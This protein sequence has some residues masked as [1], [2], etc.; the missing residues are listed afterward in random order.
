MIPDDKPPDLALSHDSDDSLNNNNDSFSHPSN[1]AVEDFPVGIDLVVTMKSAVLIPDIL[2]DNRDFQI[3]TDAVRGMASNDPTNDLTQVLDG[4]VP[5]DCR[6]DRVEK[7]GDPGVAWNDPDNDVDLGMACINLPLY[8]LDNKDQGVYGEDPVVE[9][10]EISSV[11]N[12][13]HTKDSI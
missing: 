9:F 3:Q 1:F 2:I 13:Y 5:C 10:K 6:F 4:G 12:F 11:P 8:D 7:N